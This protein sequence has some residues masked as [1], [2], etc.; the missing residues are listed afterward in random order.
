MRRPIVD[1]LAAQRRTC[2]AQ[3]DAYLMRSAGFQSTFDE[4]TLAEFLNHSDVSNGT[5]RAFRRAILGSRGAA[6]VAV[7]AIAD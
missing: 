2:F 5:L 7:S 6:S 4:G 1:P 3:V